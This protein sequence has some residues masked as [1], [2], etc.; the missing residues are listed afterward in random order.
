MPNG[1]SNGE[2]IVREIQKAQ[3]KAAEGN[4]AGA[5]YDLLAL[6]ARVEAEKG[7]SHQLLVEVMRQQASVLRAQRRFE[8]SCAVY[9]DALGRLQSSESPDPIVISAIHASLSI[10]YTQLGRS[11]TAKDSRH[12][13]LQSVLQAD[14]SPANLV[15]T[16]LLAI[17]RNSEK[18]GW[19]AAFEVLQRAARKF[20][21]HNEPWPLIAILSSTAQLLVAHDRNAAEPMLDE[22]LGLAEQLPN[23]KVPIIYTSLLQLTDSA[24]ALSR[25]AQAFRLLERLAVVTPVAGSAARAY[26][27]N[28]RI[29]PFLRQ[30]R[31]WLR[32]EKLGRETVE[33]LTAKF[34][35]ADAF[36]VEAR[37]DLAA[38]LHDQR[39]FSEASDL[40]SLNAKYLRRYAGKRDLRYAYVLNELGKA[41]D[42]IPLYREA[43]DSFRKALEIYE[44]W[45][46]ALGQNVVTLQGNL[47]ELFRIQGDLKSAEIAFRRALKSEKK[48]GRQESPLTAFLQCNLGQVLSRLGK[49]VEA[50]LLFQ[51]SAALRGKLFGENSPQRARTLLALGVHRFEIR[52]YVG[53]RNALNLAKQN[54][55]DADDAEAVVWIDMMLQGAE[56]NE[57]GKLGQTA[58]LEATVQAI[59]ECVGQTHPDLLWSYEALAKAYQISGNSPKMLNYA[60]RALHVSARKCIE[61][62][63]S[64]TPRVLADHLSEHWRFE[65]FLISSLLKTGEH[66]GEGPHLALGAVERRRALEIRAM[67]LRKPGSSRMGRVEPPWLARNPDFLKEQGL[68][69]HLSRLRLESDPAKRSLLVQEIS[70]LQSELE[71][72]EA[73][74]ART[75]PIE[76]LE[77]EILQDT[78]SL[79]SAGLSADELII[80]FVV[81]ADPFEI[82]QEGKEL[83]RYVAFVLTRNLDNVSLFDLG[84]AD[85]IDSGVVEFRAALAAGP[86]ESGRPAWIRKARYLYEKLLGPMEKELE[87]ASRL[88]IV[89]DNAIE[90][91][92]LELLAAPSGL[93][94]LD[95]WRCSYLLNI[96]EKLRF[97]HW[98]SLG[99]SVRVIAA[100]DYGLPDASVPA[101]KAQFVPLSGAVEE[102]KRVAEQF[103]VSPFMGADATEA[104]VKTSPAPEVLHICTHG[105]QLSFSQ[106]DSIQSSSSGELSTRFNRRRTLEGPWERSGLA[107]AGANRFLGQA[108]IPFGQDDG[109]LLASEVAALDLHSTDLTVLSACH[110]G[111]GDIRIGQGIAGLRSAFKATGCQSLVCSLWEVPDQLSSAFM[112]VFYRELLAK[113]SRL[114]ALEAARDV[115]RKQYPDDPFL[116]GA[117]VL[118]GDPGPL[119]RFRSPDRLTGATINFREWGLNEKENAEQAEPLPPTAVEEA[120]TLI[121]RALQ[122]CHEGSF[123]QA[124]EAASRVVSMEEIGDDLP[125]EA[126]Y[127]R[128]GAYRLSGASDEALRDYS[129]LLCHHRLSHT[130]RVSGQVDRATTYVLVGKYEEAALDYLA[131]AERPDISERQRAFIQ[132][133]LGGC[134]V[135]T[136]RETEALA[137]F[138]NVFDNPEAPPEQRLKALLNRS[139]CHRL[140]KKPELALQELEDAK[141][142]G[143]PS[144]DDLASIVL[145]RTLCLFDLGLI[146]SAGREVAPMFINE[147]VIAQRGRELGIIWHALYLNDK[148]ANEIDALIQHSIDKGELASSLGAILRSKHPA[149]N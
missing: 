80:Q 101:L 77:N 107:F 140:A 89:P 137:V 22:A 143:E 67:R 7:A 102:G 79:V 42:Q 113:G 48:A 131:L 149:E 127:C 3:K 103:G 87:S 85:D 135:N 105:F 32:A 78:Q 92:P 5:E 38:T 64:A 55:T 66:V 134:L 74:S 128:A 114:S 84:P 110:S 91:L 46:G 83:L 52:D 58:R 138:T 148:A 41:Q 70:I 98:I 63:A 125:A 133:N 121:E 75:V 88:Y 111:L 146:A 76:L 50:E 104:L 9:H 94:L 10:N 24:I 93:L 81:I 97:N 21:S 108:E 73:R 49:D 120:E 59:G 142:L 16:Q 136:G 96:G 44:Y 20:R 123:K 19:Q 11:E 31:E 29:T 118:D 37:N 18:E 33:L 145:I 99:E 26:E 45:Q 39:K 23:E 34:G 57:S 116:W 124:I 60:A 51:E 13:A 43:E 47:A 53:A 129:S 25:H 90:T 95:R 126:L 61:I 147:S 36:T 112:D 62:A 144:D 56:I 6:R 54:F 106:E 130:L 1:Q 30:G 2:I 117:F 109:L 40:L 28:L 17:A 68:R 132:V 139:E 12:R 15:V 4:L 8:E 122:W 71:Q 119:R 86:S 115:I 100:P 14:D 69:E 72:E 82:D 35:D 141:L 27:I 65:S